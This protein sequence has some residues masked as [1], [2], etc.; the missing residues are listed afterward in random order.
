[1]TSDYNAT[2]PAYQVRTHNAAEHSENRMHSDDVARQF[3]FRGALVPGV[4][5]FAH[6]TRPLVEQYGERWLAHAIAEVSLLKPAYEG[7]LLTITTGAGE[8]AGQHHLRCVNERDVEL[9]RM[10]TQLSESPM[11]PDPRA[12]STAASA[13]GERP[14][15]T[16]DLMEIGKAFPALH[17][18]PSRDDNLRWCDEVRDDLALYRHSAEPFLHPGF[19]LRQANMVLRNRFTLPAWIH[20]G[21]RLILHRPS[22]AGYAYEVRAIPEEKWIRKGH[23]FVRL[24]VSIVQSGAPVAEVIHTA[25]FNPRRAA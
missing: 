7:D 12:L 11:M 24:Y 21:S 14:I 23:E 9:A 17:W 18:R 3:G 1:M 19:I 5:V 10:S 25:I 22:R 6:M 20:T 2:L 8:Q 13:I 4:T 16:W 15:A